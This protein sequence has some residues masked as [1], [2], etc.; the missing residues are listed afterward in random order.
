MELNRMHIRELIRMINSAPFFQN[1]SM[2]IDD[3]GIGY[4]VVK[5]TL[6][7][8]H[9]SPYAAIQGGVYSSIIDTAA[10]WAP[11]SELPENVGLISMD[12]NVNN[13]ASVTGGTIIARGERIKIGRTICLSHVLVENEKGIILAEGS[14]KLLITKGLQTI[15]DMTGYSSKTMPPKFI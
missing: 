11:Y 5:I 8:K 2:A 6:E 15:P 1:L 9:L 4:S 7:N 13:L 3:M 10:Y 12:V 14:S